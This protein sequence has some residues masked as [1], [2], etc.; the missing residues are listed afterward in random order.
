M[1][2][3]TDQGPA[4]SAALPCLLAAIVLG[5]LACSEPA[6]S[7]GEDD[8]GARPDAVGAPDTSLPPD[9]GLPDV[10]PLEPDSGPRPGVDLV[11]TP[12]AGDCPVSPQ[13]AEPRFEVTVSN[14]GDQGSAAFTL[15][16]VAC[17]GG[18]RAGAS[19]TTLFEAR[20][21]GGLAPGGARTFA[22]PMPTLPASPVGAWQLQFVADAEDEVPE[23]DESNNR[24]A[25]YE[26]HNGLRATPLHLEL[27]SACVAQTVNGALRL[28]NVGT[29][30]VELQALTTLSATTELG[31]S[32]ALPVT[33]AAGSMIDLP[34]SYTPADPG[35]DEASFWIRTSASVCDLVV[36]AAGTGVAGPA[37]SEV[38]QQRAQ[39]RID[40]LVILDSS[41]SM[42]DEQPLV[43]TQL[44]RLLSDLVGAGVDFHLGLTTTDVDPGGP[45]GRLLGAPSY[46]DSSTPDGAAVWASR[47]AVGT[48]GSGFDQGLEAARLALSAPLVTTDNL[49]FLRQDASLLVL[50]VSDEDDASSGP[51]GDYLDFLEGLKTDGE[52]L[53]ANTITPLPGSNCGDVGARYL[54]LV[55]DTDGAAAEICGADW[56]DAL[57]QLTARGLGLRR[58]FELSSGDAPAEVLVDGAPVPSTAYV[59]DPASRQLSF[60]PAAIPAAG[61]TVEARFPTSCP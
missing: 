7:L 57:T 1:K 25:L 52:Q 12:Y 44:P 34:V 46:L 6:V 17:P 29:E 58:S 45:G 16:L 54:E 61:A 59:Y 2:R 56:G 27:G 42:N 31:T 5:P 51:V 47:I 22:E 28:E 43:Q 9:A 32:V 21:P 30:P 23:V 33:L 13:Y 49:G 18:C 39:P 26:L 41:C 36:S 20:L 60:V 8:A 3:S 40:A 55:D 35:R 37:Q 50:F 15:R 10:S 24:S 4:R 38:L 19:G 53:R 48:S 11:V 14:Q